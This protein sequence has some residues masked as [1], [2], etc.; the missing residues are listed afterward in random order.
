MASQFRANQFIPRTKEAHEY[1]CS[2]LD[3]PLAGQDSTTYGVNF[4]SPL[5]ELDNFNVVHNLP[6]DIMHILFEGVVPYEISLMLKSFIQTSKYFSLETLNSRICSFTYTNFEARD[7]PTPVQDKILSNPKAI[8][9]Q[10]CKFYQFMLAIKNC[11]SKELGMCINFI[12]CMK[13]IY[14]STDVEPQHQSA[15]NN[16][17]HSTTW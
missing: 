16:W 9:A 5:N 4:R 14:S 8:M 12:S 2:L 3:G 15:T 6:Q 7:I 17:G 1:H 10:S 11:R 13:S